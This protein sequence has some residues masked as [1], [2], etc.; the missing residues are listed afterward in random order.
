LPFLVRK[1]FHPKLGARPMR[2]AVEK[3]IGDA[4]AEH[5]LAGKNSGGRLLVDESRDC[6][7]VR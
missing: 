2:D 4:L 3:Q 1:G 7:I 5:L 6:L